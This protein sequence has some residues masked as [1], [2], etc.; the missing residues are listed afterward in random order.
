[1]QRIVVILFLIVNCFGAFELQLLNAEANGEAGIV[2]V[3][4]IGQNPGFFPDN[5]HLFITTNYTNL[6]GIKELHCWD[7]GFRYTYSPNQS[8][9]FKTNSIGNK[10]YRENTYT[11]GYVYK[12][13]YPI[14]IGGSM[15]LYNLTV[16]EFKAQYSVGFNLGISY[17]LS[18]A[19]TAST[20]MG[21]LNR[22]KICD[23]QEKLPEFYAFGMSWQALKFIKIKGEIF[24]D[25]LYP[26][27]FRIASIIKIHNYL[28]LFGGMQTE[29]DRFSCGISFMLKGLQFSTS[30]RT[31]LKLPNTYYFGCS[32][33][34]K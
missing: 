33:L 16:K 18:E 23:Q 28:R 32:F 34:L 10:I 9:F 27:N 2:S 25:T 1:M 4:K 21:N 5:Q 24:K 17:F 30:L 3:N 13:R 14:A 20:F 26:F 7:F 31:H 6:F 15:S 12:F 29:P 11:I 22:P 19:L 8:V